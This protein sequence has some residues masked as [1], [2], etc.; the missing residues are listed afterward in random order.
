MWSAHTA[1]ADAFDNIYKNVHNIIMSTITSAPKKPG[2]PRKE[3]R[4][5]SQL[6]Q[7]T[8]HLPPEM[9]SALDEELNGS[10]MR[11]RSE[12]IREACHTYLSQRKEQAQS[13]SITQR[14]KGFSKEERRKVMTAAA[15]TLAEYYR[16]DPEIR[17]WQALDGEDF[18]DVDDEAVS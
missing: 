8:V 16:T 12:I 11:S 10:G 9:V 7:I 6:N 14:M 4:L 2:R 5:G 15:A 18:Y 13:L 1:A 3:D 17:E